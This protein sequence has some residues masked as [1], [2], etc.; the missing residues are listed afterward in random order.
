MAKE[1]VFMVV[2][3]LVIGALAAI[4][5]VMGN[6]GNMGFCI[7]C[8]L[9]DITGALGFHRAGA[10][11][12]MRPEIIGLVIGAFAAASSAGEF[13]SRG[14]SSTLVRFFL[15]MFM[16]IGALVFLGCPLRDILRIG[17]GDLNAVVGLAGF[18]GGV[19]LGV[20]FLKRGFDLGAA[21]NDKQSQFG[22]YFLIAIAVLLLLVL[23]SGIN[24]NPEAGGP[25]FFS[26]EG[27]G[28]MH[29]PL[30]IALGAGLVVGFL[31]QKAR[32]CLSGGFR[33]FFLIRETGLLLAYL[34]IFVGVLVLNIY[35]GNFHLGFA[36]QPVA[37]SNHIF[38]F[39]GLFLVGLSAVLL[40]GC[41]LRQ[42]VLGSEGD[43]DATVSVL[44]MVAGAALAHNFMLAASPKGTTPWGEIAV[45]VGIIVVSAIGWAYR[46]VES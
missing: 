42:I 23:V 40:G 44:G 17:G 24:F 46:E 12:Y 14:G 16:M 29:A 45:V 31:A 8:F 38:N 26:K 4:L 19:L 3:G 30:W 15:G 2:I 21:R 33:D 13:K 1:K 5:V 34:G 22:G 27:P 11:Q 10:V 25:L 6:P 35:F 28:S 36:D 37:H 41:P 39:L 7:A 9:R 43:T 20:F 18:I 32:L